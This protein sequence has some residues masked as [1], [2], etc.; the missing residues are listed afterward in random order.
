[1]TDGLPHLSCLSC[2]ADP[3]LL[4]APIPDILDRRLVLLEQRLIPAMLDSL[5]RMIEATDGRGRTVLL[6]GAVF[7]RTSALLD[8]FSEL[9]RRRNGQA[10]IVLLRAHLDTAMRLHALWL[11]ED[12]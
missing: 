2:V 8:A 4:D 1:M 11:V 10:S 3:S 9:A 12:F 7:K 6:M 5:H